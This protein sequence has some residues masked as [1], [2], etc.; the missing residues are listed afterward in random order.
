MSYLKKALIFFYLV[1]KDIN[2]KKVLYHAGAL[3]YSFLMSVI[4][5]TLS[6]G[7]FIK[8]LQNFG[9]TTHFSYSSYFVP[10]FAE[11]VFHEINEAEHKRLKASLVGI[12]ISF[13]FSAG[14]IKDL[15]YAISYMCEKDS[16]KRL[17]VFYYIYLIA[18]LLFV[19]FGSFYLFLLKDLVFKH[20]IG[21]FSNLFYITFLSFLFFSLY[22]TLLPVK[23]SYYYIFSVSLIESSIT[24]YL[25]EIFAV[26]LKHAL[27]GSLIY[28]SIGF[29]IVSLVWLQAIMT[30]IL[31]GARFLFFLRKL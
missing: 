17:T 26:Y 25:K 5:L 11:K 27:I 31:L 6:I 3:S 10:Q 4:P 16:S 9:I 23:V 28:A 22:K 7:F 13:W 20:S 30:L 2:D 15:D 1:I 14:F 24:F 12:L 19:G 29:I 21:I 18:L 8:V